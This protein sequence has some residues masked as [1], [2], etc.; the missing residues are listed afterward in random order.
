[1]NNLYA[2]GTIEQEVLGVYFA[3]LGRGEAY[4]INGELTSAFPILRLGW[5]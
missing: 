4:A 5:S 3:P 1:M 2:Q